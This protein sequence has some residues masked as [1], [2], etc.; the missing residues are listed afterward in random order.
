MIHRQYSV[1]TTV[2]I[3]ALLWRGIFGREMLLSQRFLLSIFMKL[4]F[5]LY[6]PYFK[7]AKTKL[8]SGHSHFPIVSINRLRFRSLFHST[9]ARN[10]NNC[11]LKHP[12]WFQINHYYYSNASR[13]PS[14]GLPFVWYYK[15]LVSCQQTSTIEFLELFKDQSHLS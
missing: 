7:N 5:V 1:V 12:I 15:R 6:V 13:S 10:E 14:A 3:I 8:V 4:K 11:C 2:R 9:F